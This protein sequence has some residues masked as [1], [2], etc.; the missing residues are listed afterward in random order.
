MLGDPIE[1]HASADQ[2]KDLR[3]ELAI[4]RTMLEKRLNM[5]ENDVEFI[6]ALPAV[7]ELAVAVQKLAES[8]HTMD[9]KLA[10]VVN[11]Q[12]LMSLAQDLIH[13]IADEILPFAATTVSQ[14]QV[15]T[16]VENIGRKLIQLIADKEN[17]K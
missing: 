11:K 4:L 3:T 16:A 15:D 14:E 1:R 10:T 9:I 2:I 7:R 5:I 17:P 6:V 13:A 8:A 12:A